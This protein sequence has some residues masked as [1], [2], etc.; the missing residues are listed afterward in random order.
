MFAMMFD[1]MQE[2]TDNTWII[3]QKMVSENQGI[4]CFKASKHNMWI[5]D[6]RDPKKEWLQLRYCVI[7]EEV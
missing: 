1:E 2:N 3:P 5:Q 6:K 7:G 4:S